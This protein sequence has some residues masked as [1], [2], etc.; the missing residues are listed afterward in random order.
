MQAERYWTPR[1]ASML[2]RIEVAASPLA[3][4]ELDRYL[5]NTATEALSARDPE[6]LCA[7][8]RSADARSRSSTEIRFGMAIRAMKLK[9]FDCAYAAWDDGGRCWEQD[10][11]PSNVPDSRTSASTMKSACDSLIAVEA[12]TV[13]GLCTQMERNAAL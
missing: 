8:F 13:R 2:E 7:L 12:E 9:Y 11:V 3:G 1:A 6:L 5:W 4:E 10:E